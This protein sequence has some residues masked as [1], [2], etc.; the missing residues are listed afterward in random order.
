MK[1]ASLS[2][3]LHQ[4]AY[5]LLQ[6]LEKRPIN[7]YD[8]RQQLADIDLRLLQLYRPGTTTP[9]TYDKLPEPLKAC[10]L[11][12]RRTVVESSCAKWSIQK[13]NEAEQWHMKKHHR[14]LVAVKNMLTEEHLD[15][16]E[17]RIAAGGQVNAENEGRIAECY[18]HI[19]EG[20]F[21][22]EGDREYHRV[23]FP[24][25]QF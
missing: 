18:Q 10:F 24:P 14:E 1:F 25:L 20:F 15:L 23:S 13:L 3:P 6:A 19:F 12:L 16:L 4:V 11:G 5:R 2:K 8:I 17:K 7:Y 21:F 9:Q 22:T